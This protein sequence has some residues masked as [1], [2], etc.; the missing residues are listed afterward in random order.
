M[1]CVLIHKDEA[2]RQAQCQRQSSSLTMSS[3]TWLLFPSFLDCVRTEA[4]AS[5]WGWSFL[6][7]AQVPSVVRA[8]L[9]SDSRKGS[10]FSHS[11][12]K[13]SRGS[14]WPE[15]EPAPVPESITRLSLDYVLWGQRKGSGGPYNI[16][17][18]CHSQTSSRF[19]VKQSRRKTQR[20][21]SHLKSHCVSLTL[22]G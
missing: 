2:Q 18:Q 4:S 8:T 12:L 22:I 6:A 5:P 16:F 3:K 11:S 15:M 9:I 19:M 20:L 17:P 13:N 14:H 1:R 21:Y 7:A 10:S